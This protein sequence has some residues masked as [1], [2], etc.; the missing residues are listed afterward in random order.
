MKATTSAPAFKCL[1][2]SPVFEQKSAHLDTKKWR[3]RRRRRRMM[4][5]SNNSTCFCQKKEVGRFICNSTR[6]S[7][8]QFL[9]LNIF[10]ND[11]MYDVED[12]AFSALL[13]AGGLEKKVVR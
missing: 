12:T 9:V 3:M 1:E 6:A 4:T 8:M 13:G 2:V 10:M 7:G 5:L 11:E